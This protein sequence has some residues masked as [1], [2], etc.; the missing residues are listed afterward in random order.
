MS[1]IIINAKKQDNAKFILELVKRLGETGH[2]FSGDKQEDIL[3]GISMK[4]A[5]TGL[6]VS[7]NTIMK[8]L[9]SSER[10]GIFTTTGTTTL[11]KT[12][13]LICFLTN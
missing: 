3:L 12:K 8:K 1:T 9:R 4:Q 10:N 2:I 7:R 5:E 13:K 6:K 11:T